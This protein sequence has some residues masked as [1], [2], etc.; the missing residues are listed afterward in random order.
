MLINEKKWT[1]AEIVLVAH[2]SLPM[3]NFKMPHTIR[4]IRANAF[5][6]WFWDKL[7]Q[8]NILPH[9]V[10]LLK[11]CQRKGMKSLELTLVT[12]ETDAEGS[13]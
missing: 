7:V 13:H 2:F 12:Y 1:R 11:D 5:T 10:S 6:I 3:F 4:F 9:S 8:T